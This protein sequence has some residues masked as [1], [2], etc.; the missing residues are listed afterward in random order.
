MWKRRDDDDEKWETEKKVV[1]HNRPPGT[2][3]ARTVSDEITRPLLVSN[4]MNTWIDA[5]LPATSGGMAQAGLQLSSSSVCQ[6]RITVLPDGDVMMVIRAHGHDKLSPAWVKLLKSAVSTH[7][8]F[9]SHRI[10]W[11]RMKVEWGDSVDWL[12][13]ELA[14]FK[15]IVFN[16]DRAGRLLVGRIQT[17]LRPTLATSGRVLVET[18][19]W[20]YQSNEPTHMCVHGSPAVHDITS[21]A[22][23][24]P[25]ISDDGLFKR[26]FRCM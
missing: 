18:S 22:G 13:A 3:N 4:C 21:G 9:Q 2:R 17:I 12:P 19:R 8:M 14:C 16:A 11:L 23:R 5:E 1:F 6:R 15:G 25:S 20:T 24:F 10:H 7:R 26:M